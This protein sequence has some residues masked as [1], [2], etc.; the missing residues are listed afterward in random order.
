M[1]QAVHYIQ[2]HWLLLAFITFGL[3]CVVFIFAGVN[4]KQLS[5]LQAQIKATEL[6]IGDL[7][8]A[9]SV[10]EN[11]LSEIVNDIELQSTENVQVSKQLEHRIK[12]LQAHSKELAESIELLKEQ[13]P[14][15]KLYSRAYKLAAL[16]ADIEEIMAECELPKAE[17]EML[18][19]VYQ[20]S[21]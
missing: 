13:Q 11:K 3:L 18:L 16:G 6:A 21:K 8:V 14:Q 1:E 15:D 12:G 10:I 20:Q 2:T 17:V 7:Q 19:S 4:Q 9:I 5:K